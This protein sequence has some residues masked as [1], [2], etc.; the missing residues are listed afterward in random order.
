MILFSWKKILDRSKLR[1]EQILDIIEYI[2][3]VPVPLNKDDKFYSISLF[4][5]KGDN[6]IVN[7]EPIIENRKNYK[8]IELAQ[9]V[10]L[11]S[12]RNYAEYKASGKKTLDLLNSPINQ[13]AINKN[14]LVTIEGNQIVFL[15][16]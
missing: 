11:A 7:P 4:N 10:G 9:Y 16:E 5:W 6:F 14:R 12:F 13:D 3:Y 15:W 8:S 1:N 2:T